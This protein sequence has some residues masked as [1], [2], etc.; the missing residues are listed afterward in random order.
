MSGGGAGDPKNENAF[1]GLA[2]PVSTVAVA[3]GNRGRRSVAR[4]MSAAFCGSSFGLLEIGRIASPY[5]ERAYGRQSAEGDEMNNA[6]IAGASDLQP[7]S[8][9]L[10]DAQ[11]FVDASCS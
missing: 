4:I 7:N 11:K 1:G 2:P 9:S 8:A 5:E 3:C 6:H 10:Y